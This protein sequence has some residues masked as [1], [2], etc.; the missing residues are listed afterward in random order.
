MIGLL[1]GGDFFLVFPEAGG[2][3]SEVSSAEGGGFVHPWAYKDVLEKLPTTTNQQV[4]ELAPL[5]WK[6]A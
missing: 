2:K 1:L 5:K 4:A 6:A 3:T